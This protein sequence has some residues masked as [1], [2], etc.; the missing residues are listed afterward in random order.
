[1]CG[2]LGEL[3]DA[4]VAYGGAFDAAVFSV[5]DAEQ[6]VREAATIE[7]V[8]ATV[9]ALAAGRLARSDADGGAPVGPDVRRL[10]ASTGTSV[11]A[12]RTAIELGRRLADQPASCR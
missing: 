8:M 1:M 4:V 12:A 6:V 11:G 9:K 10:A 7:R 5:A 3:R 2:R